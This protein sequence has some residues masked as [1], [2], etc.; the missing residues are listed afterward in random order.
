MTTVRY[1][2]PDDGDTEDA[3][4]VFLAPKQQ[5]G[6]PL[7]LGA[8]KSSFPLPG[9]YHFRFKTS[10]G[11]L[12]GATTSGLAVWMDCVDNSK[13]VPTFES[14]IIAKVNRIS[15][16][17]E[18]KDNFFDKHDQFEEEEEEDDDSDEE[19]EQLR[20]QASNVNHNVTATNN[21]VRSNSNPNSNPVSPRASPAPNNDIFNVFDDS[22]QQTSNTITYSNPPSSHGS[23]TDLFEQDNAPS[24]DDFLSGSS[25]PAAPSTTTHSNDLLGMGTTTPSHNPTHNNL[26]A[27]MPANMPSAH[28][29]QQRQQ[30]QYPNSSNNSTFNQFPF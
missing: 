10:L 16:E 28:H 8:I 30:Q 13:P 6:S 2:I 17:D 5:S 14:S 27:S 22:Q 1:F 3:P 23:S 25:A 12:P 4:N 29:Q 11:S 7:K 9:K 20:Q 19:F 26:S 24:L 21:Y 15:L 18:E